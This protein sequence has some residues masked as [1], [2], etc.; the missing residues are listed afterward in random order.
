VQAAQGEAAGDFVVYFNTTVN[1]A[2]LLVVTAPDQATSIARFTDIVSLAD[3]Q[4]AGFGA[5]DFLFA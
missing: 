1:A 5:G 4:A 3:F 2:S